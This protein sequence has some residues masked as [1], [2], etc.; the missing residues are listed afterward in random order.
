MT[1][2]GALTTLHIFNY[3]D[4]G[5]RGVAPIQAADGHIYGTAID[6]GTVDSGTVFQ[7]TPTG[8]FT[9]VH[10]FVPKT[11]DGA[12]QVGLVQHTNGILYGPTVRGGNVSYHG[13]PTCCGTLFSVSV[14]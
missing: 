14:A 1:P 10:N 6:G 8:M 5:N 4:G 13:C 3:T 9:T 2:A 7:I 11:G 12:F